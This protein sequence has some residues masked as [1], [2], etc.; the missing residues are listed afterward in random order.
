MNVRWP[1]GCRACMAAPARTQRWMRASWLPPTPR[2]RA[3]RP[4]QP[5]VA[6]AGRCRWVWQHPCAW[7]LASPGAC[8]WNRRRTGHRI[9]LSPMPRPRHPADPQRPRVHRPRPLHPHPQPP[10][11][12]PS[13]RPPP[14]AAC[15]PPPRR[16]PRRAT[17]PAAARKRLR[18]PRCPIRPRY[19]RPGL[20]PPWRHLPHHLPR[21]LQ[22][23]RRLH[24][25]RWS[26]PGCLLP[27]PLQPNP[28]DR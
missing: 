13:A 14:R 4:R 22:R 12:A 5:A 6:D 25:G 16:T 3:R 21:F 9:G 10:P 15:H 1:P 24:P 11:P 18:P 8:S 27:P 19:R 7:R 17:P 28:C 20:R 2:R 23:W 26:K